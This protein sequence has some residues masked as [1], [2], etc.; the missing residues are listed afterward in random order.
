M[1]SDKMLH[2]E[3]TTEFGKICNE[4]KKHNPECDCIE[5]RLYKYWG[6]ALDVEILFEE[7]EIKI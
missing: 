1:L 5:E 7:K 6:K 2:Y 4:R 3:R